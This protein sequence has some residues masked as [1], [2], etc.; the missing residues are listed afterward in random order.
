PL[1]IA[2][3][4]ATPVQSPSALAVPV[5]VTALTPSQQAIADR[6]Y[7]LAQGQLSHVRAITLVR[8]YGQ[9]AVEDVADTLVARG[10]AVTNPAA[11]VV[12]L[13]RARYGSAG[14]FG[15]TED[16]LLAAEMLYV[17]VASRQPA[18]KMRWQKV[19]HL[20]RDYGRV[21]IQQ[22]I[23]ALRETPNVTN[24]AGFVMKHIQQ[25]QAAT[26]EQRPE[27]VV[28]L[29]MEAVRSLA[30]DHAMAKPKAVELVNR[31]GTG[32][33]MQAIRVLK[34]RHGIENPAGFVVVYLRSSAKKAQ[35]Q[36]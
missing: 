35:Q 8:E 5:V 18:R 21:V 17:A 3:I 34:A 26:N 15:L 9:Y 24:P 33:V 16:E 27:Q 1:P 7:A 32:L 6:L 23:A 2:D 14:Q 29:L 12:S 31:Y 30:P 11:F 19:I 25:G 4:A 28:T 13:L 36:A 20:V 10:D 22:A